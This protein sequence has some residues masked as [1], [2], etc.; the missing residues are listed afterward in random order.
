MSGCIVAKPVRGSNCGAD[1][2]TVVRT[3]LRDPLL[4]RATTGEQQREHLRVARTYSR[5]STL[6]R[7]GVES[8]DSPELRPC[9]AIVRRLQRDDAVQW[10]RSGGVFPSADEQSQK[11]RQ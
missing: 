8:A 5:R 11:P 7:E 4:L 6:S 1:D 10:K 2:N 3:P 9:L